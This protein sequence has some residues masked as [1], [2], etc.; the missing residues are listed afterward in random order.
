[1]KKVL[2]LAVV[3]LLTTFGAKAQFEKGTMLLNPS[4]TGLD[5]S[6]SKATKTTFGLDVAGGYFLMDNFALV[7]EMGGSWSSP[8]DQYKLAGK[9][10]YYFD[11]VGIYASAGLQLSSYQAKHMSSV[12]DFAL[13]MDAGYAYFISK[14]V[15]IEPG[16][17]LD[18]SFR[19][20]DNT[21]F[22]LKV[23]FG[24]YF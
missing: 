18:L 23:G 2:L 12:N 4:I 19:E 24:F 10:R 1:M 5:L 22:G 11:K 14:N 9:A 6:Y 7:G 8:V 21:R 15:S 16:V 17:Y 3:T 13:V 20:S